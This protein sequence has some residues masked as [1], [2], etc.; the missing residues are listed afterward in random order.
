MNVLAIISESS[1]LNFKVVEF[2]GSPDA[3][4]SRYPSIRYEG[5]AEVIR[6]AA[7]LMLP[8]DGKT[9]TQFTR[10]KYASRETFLVPAIRH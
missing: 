7:G 8:R 4:D 9:V 3:A 10:T 1:S 2:G 5:S 6:L